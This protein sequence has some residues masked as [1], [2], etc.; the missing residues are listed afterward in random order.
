MQVVIYRNQI[1]YSWWGNI[2]VVVNTGT[3]ILVTKEFFIGI[4]SSRKPAVL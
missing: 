1:V 2:I 4:I 3:F